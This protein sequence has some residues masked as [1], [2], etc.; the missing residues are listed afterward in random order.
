MTPRL[1]PM[2]IKTEQK[3]LVG[4]L[5]SKL[6]VEILLLIHKAGPVYCLEIEQL[7]EKNA[8]AVQSQLRQMKTVGVLRS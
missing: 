6:R 4:F 3:G 2:R 5:G 1:D 8:F 7:F